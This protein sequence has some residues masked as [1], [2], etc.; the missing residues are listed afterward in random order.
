MKQWKKERKENFD[1]DCACRCQI[2]WM[3]MR[4]RRR[5]RETAVRVITEIINTKDNVYN[6]HSHISMIQNRTILVSHDRK[7]GIEEDTILSVWNGRK[8]FCCFVVYIFQRTLYWEKKQFHQNNIRSHVY[9]WNM[10]ERWCCYMTF[11]SSQLRTYIK[12]HSKPT[13]KAEMS[14]AVRSSPPPHCLRHDL[15]ENS[16]IWELKTCLNID[17]CR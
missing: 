6:E 4:R 14:M 15:Q 8:K 11:V 5:M 7:G 12:P 2:K 3:R 1:K 13:V 9:R 10:C 17:I 16:F